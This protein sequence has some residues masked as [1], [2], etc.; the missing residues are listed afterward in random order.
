M[1]FRNLLVVVPHSGIII[2]REIPLGSLSK[3]FPRLMRNVDWHTDSLYDFRDFLD[4][5]QLVFPYCFLILDANRHPEQM[6]ECIPI[7]D[8]YGEPIYQIG[9]EPAMPLRQSLS[10]KYLHTF[11]RA[12]R[13]E[14]VRGKTFLLD[15]HSTLTAK[16]VKDNQIDLMNSQLSHV[17]EERKFFCPDVFIETYANE[18]QKRLPNVQVT[19]NQSEYDNVYGHVCGKHS[20]NAMVGV[21]GK[22]PAILQETNQKLY[23][24]EDRT[25]NVEAQET[26]RRAFA[27]A[28][29]AMKKKV[30]VD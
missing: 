15:A 13:E 23:V 19:V 4:N 3:G 29:Y 16:G 10:K 12:I 24:N 5:S 9:L 25:P 21:D 8:A 28:L 18:L 7:K 1:E 11:H 6:D 30:C 27:E 20:M 17:E 22:V 2:P 26:L 14:I